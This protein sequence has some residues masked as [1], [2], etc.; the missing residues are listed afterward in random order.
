[1][2]LKRFVQISVGLTVAVL[3]AYGGFKLAQSGLETSVED[4]NQEEVD[5]EPTNGKPEEVEV[6]LK[7][8]NNEDLDELFPDTMSEYDMQEAIHYMSHGLVQANQK[9]GKIEL[10]EDRVER[11]LYVAEFNKDTYTHGNRYITILM[12]WN[13]GDFSNA[14]DDHNFIWGLWNGT[15]GK[16]TRL[17]TSDEIK[18][19]NSENFN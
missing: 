10:T 19:Y 14:V 18:K 16:A 12:G 4:L 8:T 6:V 5:G 9:W 11:L 2:K 7:V 13:N 15:V 1:M 3:I 17:L